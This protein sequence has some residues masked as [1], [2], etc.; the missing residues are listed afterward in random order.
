MSR[1]WHDIIEDAVDRNP[2]PAVLV[3]IGSPDVEVALSV[4][5][6]QYQ[7]TTTLSAPGAPQTTRKWMAP[8]RRLASAGFPVPPVTGDL[9]RIPSLGTEARIATVGAG[10]AGGEVVRWDI[11]E[12]GIG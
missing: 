4:A 12:E 6:I 8:G 1:S 2:V 9:I 7:E 10:I 11:L 5:P 3:R